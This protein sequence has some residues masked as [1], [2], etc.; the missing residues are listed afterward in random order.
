VPKFDPGQSKDATQYGFRVTVNA[1][2]NKCLKPAA[3]TIPLATAEIK[4]LYGND[5][6]LQIDGLSAF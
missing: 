2:F 5:F 3:S 1:L 4:K 6:F